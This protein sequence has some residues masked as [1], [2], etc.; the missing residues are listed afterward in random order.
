MV[1]NEEISNVLC[2]L[3]SSQNSEIQPKMESLG[4]HL[5]SVKCSDEFIDQR[6][7]L[8]LGLEVLFFCYLLSAHNSS[9]WVVF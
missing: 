2:Q 7:H 3:K 1:D 4:N 6:N 8:L 9:G 5:P